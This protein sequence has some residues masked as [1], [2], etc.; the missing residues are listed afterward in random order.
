MSSEV[1][2]LMTAHP[3]AHDLISQAWLCGMRDG[4][5]CTA[6][7]ISR[8]LQDNDLPEEIQRILRAVIHSVIL[9][10]Y[11]VEGPGEG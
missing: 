6:Q 4:I 5:A 3:D 9:S 2:D 1:S 10:G 7:G 8:A 11:Q